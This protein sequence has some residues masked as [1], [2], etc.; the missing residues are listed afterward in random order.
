MKQSSHTPLDCFIAAL[1]AMTEG[2]ASCNG[3]PSP[4]P[5]LRSA[6]VSRASLRGARQ[7]SNPAARTPGLFQPSASHRRT[8][9][10]HFLLYPPFLP[11]SPTKITHEIRGIMF[12][13]TCIPSGAYGG[14]PLQNAAISGRQFKRLEGKAGR[15]LST[16][17]VIEMIFFVLKLMILQICFVF[18]DKFAQQTN[19]FV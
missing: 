15:L 9:E 11:I 10:K 3:L 16:R 13:P 19:R 4:Q 18:Y 17:N 14:Y 7:C 2:G 1:F 8:A 5:P 6:D 12:I